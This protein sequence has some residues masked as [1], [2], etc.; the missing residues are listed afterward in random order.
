LVL[1]TPGVIPKNPERAVYLA[2][3][4]PGDMGAVTDEEHRQ[5][6]A[7]LYACADLMRENAR[8]REA[9]ERIE[10]SA[11][12]PWHSLARETLAAYH[13]AQGAGRGA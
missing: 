10:F 12:E 11:G 7:Y 13:A 3:I 2:H 4:I 8:L 5:A 1:V 6:A 9:L